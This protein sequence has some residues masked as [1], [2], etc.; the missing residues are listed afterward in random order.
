MRFAARLDEAGRSAD[1]PGLCRGH[2][3][4][5]P[6][7]GTSQSGGVLTA[8]AGRS[9]RWGVDRHSRTVRNMPQYHVH[10][11]KGRKRVDPRVVELPDDQSA[12]QYGERLAIGLTTLSQG[13][14]IHHLG[15]WYVNVID[16]E[17]NCVVQC[18][19]STVKQRAGTPGRS[20]VQRRLPA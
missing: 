9:A 12:K 1:R 14:R 8:I 4:A 3:N 13:F 5:N 18:K 19:V 16:A 17:G 7:A 10:V 2:A 11:A 15:N 6:A 20:D